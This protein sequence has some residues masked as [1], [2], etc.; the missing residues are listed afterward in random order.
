MID[1]SEARHHLFD[2]VVP[3][4]GD[5]GRRAALKAHVAV[6]EEC[7]AELEELQRLDASLHAA[8]PL[9]DPSPA[10]EARVLALPS[11]GHAARQ[12]RPVPL[13]E[14]PAHRSRGWHS[15]AAWRAAAAA[16]A[17]A[18]ACL[19]AVLLT[20]A[21]PAPGDDPWTSGRAVQVQPAAGSDVTGSA[22]LAQGPDGRSAVRVAVE[23]LR[24]VDGQWY[25]LW[26]ARS[27]A[28]RVSLGRFRPD[29]DGRLWVVVSLPSLPRGDY[30]GVWLTREP[31]DGDPRWTRDWVFRAQLP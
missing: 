9:P 4:L 31:D 23:G 6:C 3:G 24:P 8:G 19:A 25:E 1:H 29:A 22:A 26:L 12:G 21:D 5:P 10:L 30:G 27:P 16:L 28:E 17:V 11:H 14:P 7:R 15:V 13:A 20:D 18:T 2:L